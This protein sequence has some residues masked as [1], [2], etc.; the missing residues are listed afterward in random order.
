[1]IAAPGLRPIGKWFTIA[2]SGGVVATLTWASGASSEHARREHSRREATM[3][4]ATFASSP[5]TTVPAIATPPM[6]AAE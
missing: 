6:V 2:L 5:S 3:A 1:M 4:P